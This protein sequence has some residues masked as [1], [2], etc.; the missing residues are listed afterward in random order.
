MIPL[1][2]VPSATSPTPRDG[3]ESLV[4][5]AILTSF[6][7]GEDRHRCGLRS[8]EGRNDR[9]LTACRHDKQEE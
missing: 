8:H 6:P 3:V 5:E 1:L 7:S 9:M 4:K 2:Q